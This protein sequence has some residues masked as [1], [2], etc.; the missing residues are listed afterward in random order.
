M[1]VYYLISEVKNKAM[2]KPEKP[3]AK[4]VVIIGKNLSLY[5][6]KKG[7]EG[8]EDVIFIGDGRTEI[9]KLSL[10]GLAGKTTPDTLFILDAHGIMEGEFQYIDGITAKSF[11]RKLQ[12]QVNHPITVSFKACFGG[13]LLK[14]KE[15]DD[16]ISVL[17]EA[18]RSHI[19]LVPLGVKSIRQNIAQKLSAKSNLEI[20]SQNIGSTP[21]TFYF[22]P[23]PKVESKTD[24]VATSKAEKLGRKFSRPGKFTRKDIWAVL[25]SVY[26]EAGLPDNEIEKRVSEDLKKFD[27]TNKADFSIN[28]IKKILDLND[29]NLEQKEQNGNLRF[30]NELLKK[31]RENL[32]DKLTEVG[33]KSFLQERQRQF[34]EFAGLAS[35]DFEDINYKEARNDFRSI[36]FMR[37]YDEEFFILSENH[38][39]TKK[40]M[41]NIIKFI[42]ETHWKII[43]KV[44]N[45]VDEDGNSPM[46]VA[47]QN[48]ELYDVQRLIGFGANVNIVNNNGETL[49]DI[50]LKLRN[51][52]NNGEVKE[53][54]Y[55]LHDSII[56]LLNDGQ[57]HKEFIKESFCHGV[58]DGSNVGILQRLILTGMDVNIVSRDQPIISLATT[59][60]NP[61]ITKILVEGGVSSKNINSA[62]EYAS[63]GIAWRE[64]EE[65]EDSG[66]VSFGKVV[67]IN[68]IKKSKEFLDAVIASEIVI[69]E[70]LKIDSPSNE[71]I[72]AENVAK[73]I[74]ELARNKSEHDLSSNYFDLLGQPDKSRSVLAH[75]LL[76]CEDVASI[77]LVKDNL[78]LFI[79]D[80]NLHRKDYEGKTPLD[81]V[82]SRANDLTGEARDELVAIR[83]TFL[84]KMHKSLESKEVPE[85]KSATPSVTIK[86]ESETVLGKGTGMQTIEIN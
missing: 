82:T 4:I 11:V 36:A 67:D 63:T 66:S 65:Y 15:L 75:L 13:G 18:G 35:P 72:T 20:F 23:F 31:F 54:S 47:A 52:P 69:K 85:T 14:R 26:K 17:T 73:I 53:Y 41:S 57:K 60:G 32:R 3:K 42:H 34:N 8:L 5:D 9:S 22:L 10:E 71:K 48:G 16:Q 21:E 46:M 33:L 62:I 30:K 45:M 19:S 7:F 6:V 81:I 84:A 37:G 40:D 12:R 2:S 74:A 27:A 64:E 79:N 83:E 70:N 43:D 68:T 58:R 61:E 86:P 50:V 76:K 49:L 51:A 28:K 24:E 56:Q 80:K 25:E 29:E 44:I 59:S 39:F 38:S 77:R 78:D 55:L 1:I